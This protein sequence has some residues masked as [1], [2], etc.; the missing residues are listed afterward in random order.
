MLLA[1]VFIG[2]VVLIGYLS[3]GDDVPKNLA[4]IFGIGSKTDFFLFIAQIFMSVYITLLIYLSVLS[5]IFDY[6]IE[7]RANKGRGD[8]ILHDFRF[9]ILGNQNVRLWRFYVVC[10]LLLLASLMMGKVMKEVLI[11]ISNILNLVIVV[12]IPCLLKRF[13]SLKDDTRRI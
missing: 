4:F 9:N 7:E 5:S 10:I 1:S 8:E 12:L 2:Y 13:P 11:F 3:F 6:E